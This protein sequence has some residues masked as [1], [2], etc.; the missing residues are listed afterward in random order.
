MARKALEPTFSVP[1]SDS[2]L[3]SRIAADYCKDDS[4]FHPLRTT[5]PINPDFD[6]L[7][8]QRRK[9]DEQ[10]RVLLVDV[11]KKQYA[12]S[13]ILNESSEATINK[14]LQ[15]NTFTVTTGQ[16]VGLLLGPLYTPLKI[17]SAV[18]L[19]TDLKKK[20]ADNDFIPVF[21]MATEDHDIDEIR[22]FT[23]RGKKYTCP[24]EYKG[25]AGR[26]PCS[27]ILEWLQQTD[28][29]SI[30]PNW[31]ELL[32]A[33]YSLPTLAMATRYLVH[34]L[35]GSY[36]VL[37]IDADDASLKSSFADIIEE[38][39]FNGH[40]Y[41]LSRTAIDGIAQRYPVQLQ[42]RDINFFYLRDN[43]RERIEKEA[44]GFK[45]ADQGFTWDAD[46][47]ATEIHVHPE[48]F[49]PNALT[50]PVYQE[51]LLP[52]IACFGGA[53]EIAYWLELKAVME[54]YSVGYPALLLRN[55][56][57]LLD[58][59]SFHRLENSGF[60]WADLFLPLIDL[61]RRKL[62][63]ESQGVLDLTNELKAFDAMFNR[64]EEKASA[65]NLPTKHSAMAMQMRLK[66]QLDN[67]QKKMLRE[68][69]K[70][71]AASLSQ[72]RAVYATVF[73]N[74]ALSERSESLF[75]YMSSENS[76]LLKFLLAAM[77]SNGNLL[78]MCRW[79][80]DLS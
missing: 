14:L 39:I 19:C 55:S 63:N 16:Q 71:E 35:F 74:G 76:Q 15:Q 26:M 11:L 66:K 6:A 58:G 54:H 52:N 27:A 67:F 2:G 22:S 59:A 21:W 7:I 8:A 73:P 36:G 56:A 80:D 41:A 4:F 49:S 1:L 51:H 30:I 78:V 18:S 75:T 68:A 9:F 13:G 65:V 34:H 33:A 53:A 60:N 72:I 17:L 29:F 48:R 3:I 70:K 40:S 37:C 69:R 5:S 44:V 50:R 24:I 12:D 61:E 43:Y 23:I 31:R 25:S 20:H 32:T 47:L 46:A 10:K 57:V 64:I 62:L 79:H 28:V 77:S 45:T 38:D 42:G